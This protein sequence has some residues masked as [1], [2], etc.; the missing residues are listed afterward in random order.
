MLIEKI[1][2]FNES[3]RKNVIEQL[4]QIYA[5]VY[6]WEPKEKQKDKNTSKTKNNNE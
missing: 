1:I 6:G 2:P 4:T 3:Q 5:L